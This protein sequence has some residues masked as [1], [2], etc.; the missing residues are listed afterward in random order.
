MISSGAGWHWTERSEGSGDEP[1]PDWWEECFSTMEGVCD[2]HV[3]IGHMRVVI[4]KHPHCVTSHYVQQPERT[5][6]YTPVYTPMRWLQCHKSCG[7]FKS[8]LKAHNV[9]D[10]ELHRCHQSTVHRWIEIFT[11]INRQPVRSLMRCC[12][13]ELSWEYQCNCAVVL[14]VV[15]WGSYVYCSMGSK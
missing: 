11:A 7:G 13:R 8:D 14:S 15:R 9:Y 2:D 5:P 10:H 12:M 3:S 1:P 6:V 4:Y